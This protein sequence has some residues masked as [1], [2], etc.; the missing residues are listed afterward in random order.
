L[1]YEPLKGLY[2]YAW[3]IGFGVS[4][5]VHLVLMKLFPPKEVFATDAHG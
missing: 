4:A 3:F 5:V 2:D 1:V